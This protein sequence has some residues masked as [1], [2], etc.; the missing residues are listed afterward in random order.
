MGIRLAAA[1]AAA[2]AVL[3]GVEGFGSKS[4]RAGAAREAA[5]VA[6]REFLEAGRVLTAG[7]GVA[8][9][10]AA[11]V[12]RVLGLRF[13]EL[14]AAAAVVAVA[15]R[16]SRTMSDRRGAARWL[17]SDPA[18]HATAR[19]AMMAENSTVRIGVGEAPAEVRDIVVAVEADIAGLGS[20]DK[21]LQVLAGCTATFC[22]CQGTAP[23][24]VLV[25]LVVG[26]SLGS[27]HGL[28]AV[29]ARSCRIAVCCQ[30]SSFPFRLEGS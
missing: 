12:R 28:A 22:S 17:G 23:S 26:D 11:V 19:T 3:T 24:T 6:G 16:H 1:A 8:V 25:H 29:V 2:V 20:G 10:E 15:A 9:A 14:M 21:E 7:R 30:S 4:A 5:A 27:H 18:R 13:V